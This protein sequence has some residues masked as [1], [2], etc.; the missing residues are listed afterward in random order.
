M[1]TQFDKID[2]EYM[3]DLARILG[4]DSQVKLAAAKTA[5]AGTPAEKR[6]AKKVASLEKTASPLEKL[7]S[8]NLREVL[9][10]ENFRR[11]V[12]DEI[13]SKRSTWEPMLR[14]LIE[15]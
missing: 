13:E 4:T 9:E 5:P 10:D 12:F 14:S 1:E 7:A 15:E 3:L 11:G 6:A 8:M 2:R